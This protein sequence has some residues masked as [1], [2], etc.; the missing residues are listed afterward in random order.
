VEN[1]AL[2]GEW[3]KLHDEELHHLYPS[4]N[5]IRRIRWAEHVVLVGDK[6]STY[7]VLVWKAEVRRPLGRRSIDGRITLLGS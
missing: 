2:R 7:R 1:G 3:R 5:I 4:P 6:R